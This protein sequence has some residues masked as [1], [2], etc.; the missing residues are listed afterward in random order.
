MTTTATI[1]DECADGR[2]ILRRLVAVP[3]TIERAG[4]G[5]NIASTPT[6]GSISVM[7]FHPRSCS[8]R[9]RSGP[10]RN[11]L[12]GSRGAL[13]GQPRAC[14]EGSRKAA[15]PR[16]S[17]SFRKESRLRRQLTQR[18]YSRLSFLLR[19]MRLGQTIGNDGICRW[20]K[21]QPNVSA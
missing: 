9:K 7:S 15:V 3:L 10:G 17:S 16:S 20:I 5:C 1:L 14:T 13:A 21:S 19:A 18:D 8:T 2:K 6:T 12:T 11:H 4:N